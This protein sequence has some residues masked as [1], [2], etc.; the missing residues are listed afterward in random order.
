MAEPTKQETESAQ[1]K[2]YK[3]ISGYIYAGAIIIGM[4]IGFAVDSLIAGIFIGVGV[5][6]L[7]VAWLNYKLSR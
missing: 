1:Q 6:L 4:G 3:E 5:A 7:T 2:K